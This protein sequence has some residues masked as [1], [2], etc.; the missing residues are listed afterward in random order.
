M[1]F[2]FRCMPNCGLCCRLSPVTVLPHEV[3]LIEREAEDLG[4]DVRFKVG[5]TVVDLVNKVRLALSYLMM[6]NDDNVCPFLT[7]DNKC[8]VHNRYKPLT[9]RSYP[10]LPRVIRYSLDPVTKTIDFEVSYGAS[11]ACPVVKEGL[12][13]GSLIRVSVDTSFARRIFPR[14]YV[15]A[16][17]MINARR[18]YT[19][20]LSYLWR[21]GEVDLVEDNGTYPYPVVNSYWFIRSRFPQLTLDVILRLSREGVKSLE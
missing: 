3:Y 1:N 12:S 18:I 15:A 14:E 6:L 21:S 17:E 5:Y 20:Y 2:T 7:S 16:E 11:T 19:H 10:F 9:C 8:L 13:N 4:V